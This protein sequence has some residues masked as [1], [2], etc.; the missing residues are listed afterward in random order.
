MI[1][2][3]AHGSRHPEAAPLTAEITKAA[4]DILSVPWHTT[5]LDN[6]DFAAVEEAVAQGKHVVVIPMLFTKAF[7]ATVDVPAAIAEIDTS[8][9]GH[10]V[11]ADILG[12]GDDIAEVISN[13][14]QA[15]APEDAPL[16]IYAVGSSHDAANVAV[17]DL[18]TQVSK[19]T[20]RDVDLYFAT[21]GGLDIRPDAH[22]IPLFTT[23]GLLLNRIADHEQQSKPLGMRLVDIVVSRYREAV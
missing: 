15:E 22:V 21:R 16:A 6:P 18:T 5:D 2:T 17:A 1:V 23:F 12:T 20:G 11:L 10:V 13:I 8:G 3:L 19:L 7:H 4:A 9:P 14:A